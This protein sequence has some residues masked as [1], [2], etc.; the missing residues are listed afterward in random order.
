MTVDAYELVWYENL[1]ILNTE[2]FKTPKVKIYP[3]P[4]KDVLSIEIPNEVKTITIYNMLG[5]KLKEVT[6]NLNKI[7]LI[8]MPTGLL[9]IE[10][11]T[12]KGKVIQ[13]IIKE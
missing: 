11:E 2:D 10:I 1:T 3:N 8:N 4:A 12:D 7:S 6:Q 5:I 9:F 13:K